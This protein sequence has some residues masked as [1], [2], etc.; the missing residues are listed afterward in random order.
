[1]AL[2]FSE[3]KKEI[4]MSL[5]NGKSFWKTKYYL[6]LKYC[7]SICHYNIFVKYEEVF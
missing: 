3:N 1:M 4:Q 6:Y 7:T 5:N 2:E